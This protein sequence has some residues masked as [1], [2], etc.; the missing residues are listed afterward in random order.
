M[1]NKNISFILPAEE[2]KPLLCYYLYTLD[3]AYI[4]LTALWTLPTLELG[5]LDLLQAEMRLS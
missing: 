5:E 4:V 2:A 3:S 1:H